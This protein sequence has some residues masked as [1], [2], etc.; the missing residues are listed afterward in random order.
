MYR[1]L[2]KSGVGVL[3]DGFAVRQHPIT[4]FLAA[5]G[6]ESIDTN[7]WLSDFRKAVLLRS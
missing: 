1:A 2:L 7:A 3:A 4:S 6:R 5:P